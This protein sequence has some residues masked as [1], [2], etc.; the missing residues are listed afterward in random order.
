M[1]TRLIIV[2]LEEKQSEDELNDVMENGLAD[3][4]AV[5]A[6][7]KLATTWALLKAKK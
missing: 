5:D 6:T 1:R 3:Y 7:G 4:A 2:A